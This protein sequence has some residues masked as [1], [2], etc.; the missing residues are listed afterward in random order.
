VVIGQSARML[1]ESAVRG[2]FAPI[3]IDL[4][5]DSDTRKIARCIQLSSLEETPV[6]R[7]LA[8]IVTENAGI[9]LVYGSGVDTRP[10][11][12]EK[13]SG[14]MDLSGNP[15]SVLRRM[16]DPASF[17]GLL[18]S[19]AIPYPETRVG[20]PEE[21]QTWLFKIPFT[22]GGRGVLSGAEH[23]EAAPGYYQ[24][25]L[26][27]PAMSVLFLASRRDAR[28]I[29][30]NTQWCAGP[31]P[32]AATPY[33]FSGIMNCAALSFGQQ[34]QLRDYVNRLVESVSLA[35]L[36]SLDFV[37]EDGE[38]KVLELNPRP[39]ASL[40]LYDRCYPRGLLSE[41]IN[42]VKGS[43]MDLPA[44]ASRRYRGLEIV[45]ADQSCQV[46]TT[47]RWPNWTADRPVAGTQ[48]AAGEPL[49]TVTAVA[50]SGDA[51]R[52]ILT[53]RRQRIQ[54]YFR[55]AA[56]LISDGPAA[57]EGYNTAF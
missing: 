39:G 48:V 23:P 51:L 40:M 50:A 34:R 41:H 35:G 20:R 10:D 49:C 47:A 9:S 7:A 46:G 6:L 19:L 36:N 16:H 55:G 2:G 26:A 27:G 5:A 45:Y 12:V 44:R 53:Q 32:D 3:A 30:F 15:P 52:R 21:P 24:K 38:C 4:F 11:L 42:S 43:T 56:G 33:R 14:L 25:K 22:E 29:G 54:D 18:D 13:I 8:A 37:L 17:F 31:D 1:A 28:I 57:E